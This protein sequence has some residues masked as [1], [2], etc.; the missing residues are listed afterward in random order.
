[1]SNAPGTEYRFSSRRVGRNLCSPTKVPRDGRRHTRSQRADAMSPRVVDE[2]RGRHRSIRMAA[3][4]PADAREDTTRTAAAMS[5]QSAVQ[6]VPA[7]LLNGGGGPA[8]RAGK[9]PV[10]H[11]ASCALGI[12]G[13]RR[14]RGGIGKPR[15]RSCAQRRSVRKT[16][17]LRQRVGPTM[18][19]RIVP[20]TDRAMLRGRLGE[21]S[22]GS[23]RSPSMPA[24]AQR[25]SRLSQSAVSPPLPTSGEPACCDDAASATGRLRRGGRRAPGRGAVCKG[26]ETSRRHYEAR[27]QLYRRRRGPGHRSAACARR[28][29]AAGGTRLAPSSRGLG[30][31]APREAG[32][33]AEQTGPIGL[34]RASC[35]RW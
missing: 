19:R 2:A 16:W 4:T 7:G 26:S 9:S 25:T 8:G 27:D 11:H 23:M 18:T 32:G 6:E 35:R 22:R 17:S 20:G 28:Y 31:L 12:G 15:R 5:S 10:S 33:A 21:Q 14:R 34:L 13:Q 30:R 29:H 24:G 1:M 3:P